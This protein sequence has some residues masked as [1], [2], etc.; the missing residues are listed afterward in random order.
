MEKESVRV[1]TPFQC[2]GTKKHWKPQRGSVSFKNQIFVKKGTSEGFMPFQY[3]GTIKHWELQEKQ[4]TTYKS[5]ICNKILFCKMFT[6][7]TNMNF[8]IT[9]P[10]TSVAPLAIIGESKTYLSQSDAL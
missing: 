8:T 10:K 9:S 4:G 2:N 6:R 1:L 3:D 7:A 5:H